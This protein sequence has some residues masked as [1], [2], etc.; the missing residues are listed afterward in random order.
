MLDKGL[1]RFRIVSVRVGVVVA[2][3]VVQEGR[4]K[5]VLVSDTPTSL[6]LVKQPCFSII[7]L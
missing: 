1:R 7:G 2:L 3:V 4:K 5:D 6:S